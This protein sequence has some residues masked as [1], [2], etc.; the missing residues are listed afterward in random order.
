[1]RGLDAVAQRIA[2]FFLILSQICL[3]SIVVVMTVEAFARTF[4]STSLLFTDEI[5]GYLFVGIFFL[6]LPFCIHDGGLL[7]ID[8]LLDRLPS[9]VASILDLLFLAIGIAFCIPLAYQI[10]RLVSQSYTRSVTSTTLLQTPLAIPQ[11]IMAVGML[12]VLAILAARLIHRL[13]TLTGTRPD[14]G[15]AGPAA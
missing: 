13:A 9:R 11:S 4:L 1:M 14:R 7:R 5:A 8:T 6:G 3:F 15:E 10:L 2:A 12:A